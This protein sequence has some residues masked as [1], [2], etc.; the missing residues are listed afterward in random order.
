MKKTQKRTSN[1]KRIADSVTQAASIIKC[2]RS[3]LTFSKAAG[4]GAFRNGRVYLDELLLWLEQNPPDAKKGKSLS[5]TEIQCLLLL[6]KVKEIQN[7]NSL[8]EGQYV[9]KADVK[10]QVTAIFYKQKMILLQALRCEL[11]PKL[12][13]LRAAEMVPQ[14]EEIATK[15]LNSWHDIQLPQED[16]REIYYMLAGRNTSGRLP[17][18]L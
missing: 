9:K 10:S 15:I 16:V 1:G 6:Q 7:K 2:P 12:E 3:V 17:F 4:C 14:M 11:P 8:F 13:G 5:K 18:P